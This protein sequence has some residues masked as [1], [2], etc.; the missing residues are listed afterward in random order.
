MSSLRCARRLWLPF[1][2]VVA[3]APAAACERQVSG[4]AVAGGADLTV[5]GSTGSAAP[6]DDPGSGLQSRSLRVDEFPAGY[7]AAQIPAAQA[8]NL[9]NDLTG[10]RPGATTAPAGCLPDSLDPTKAVVLDALSP[11]GDAHLSVVT[12]TVDSPLATVADQARRCPRYTVTS[13]STRTSVVTTMLPPAPVTSQESIALRREVH[14]LS[15]P[16]QP[17]T[18]S[19]ILIAQNNGIRVYA[20]YVGTG[21]SATPDGQALDEVFT[22]AVK[23]SRGQ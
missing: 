16:T 10:A 22:K 13:G 21:A 9:L 8:P 14:Q 18:T 5:V 2:L 1:A 15:A 4:S 6:S 17:V 12:A 20:A 11:S 23:R 19:T 3:I 7:S